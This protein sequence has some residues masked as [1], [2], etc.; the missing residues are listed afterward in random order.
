LALPH[1]NWFGSGVALTEYGTVG[2][3]QYQAFLQSTVIPQIHAVGG[4]VSYNHPYGVQAIAALP[5]ASQNQKL[6]AVASAILKNRALAADILEV[7]YPLRSGV[8]LAHHIALWDVCSRNALFLT[9]NGVSDDH[10]GTDWFHF[11]NNWF[12]SVWA[13]SNAEADLLSALSA[14]RSWCASLSGYRGGLDLLVD[15]ACPMGSASVSARTSRQLTVI[16]TELPTKSTLQ[17]VR[18]AVDYAGTTAPAP[19]TSIIASYGAAALSSGSVTLP[20]DCT[21][22]SFVRAQV[23]NSSGTIVA[24]SNPAWLLREVP[25]GGIPA[26]RA[27]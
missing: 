11:G 27:C 1:I 23:V 26:P 21:V 3:K 14:G 25:P 5:Q 9:G 22:S 17:V 4:L 10:V 15:G 18:G 24:L 13:V 12:T 6:T 20:V 16:A 19:N 2:A 8:D 7:G